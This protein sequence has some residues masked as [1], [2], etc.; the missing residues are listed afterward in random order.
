MGL[1]MNKK[2]VALATSVGFLAM[3]GAASAA[4]F[5]YTGGGGVIPDNVASGVNFD[6]LVV[7]PGSITSFDRVSLTIFHTFA[8]DLTATLQHVGTG[9]TVSLFQ[10]I[11]GS[12][13]LGLA[14]SSTPFTYTFV[15]NLAS[16]YGGSDSWGGGLSAVI[17]A[18]TY[19][20]SSG[21]AA[22]VGPYT[23]T[24]LNVF[25]GESLAGTWRLHI[26]DSAPIDTGF[27]RTFSFGGETGP[28]GVPEPASWGLMIAGFGGA[29]AM[30]RRRRAARVAL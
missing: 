6:L 4:S 18:G 19:A 27:V 5:M 13:D 3:S 2:L 9:T 24:N 15:T 17:P 8:A 28:T 23:P 20:A 25:A 16:T 14:S 21:G 12:R 10:Q 1:V 26:S 22:G 30:L 11:G 29:G 7:G